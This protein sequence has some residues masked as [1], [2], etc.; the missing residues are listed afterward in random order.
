[1]AILTELPEI[2]DTVFAPNKSLLKAID[3]AQKWFDY[4]VISD[5]P[6]DAPKRFPPRAPSVMLIV[7]STPSPAA[8]KIES[9]S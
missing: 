1:L 6:E 8:S 7:V 3:D 2:T 9:P 5:F 4:L